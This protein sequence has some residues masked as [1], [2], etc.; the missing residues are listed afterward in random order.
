MRQ[1]VIVGTLLGSLALMLEPA[2]ARAAS[3]KK[4]P[5]TKT[6]KKASGSGSLPS[7]VAARLRQMGC[8]GDDFHLIMCARPRINAVCQNA[9][10]E[11]PGCQ[12]AAVASKAQACLNASGTDAPIGNALAA[13]DAL[14]KEM[15]TA[16][17]CNHGYAETK[18]LSGSC[19]GLASAVASFSCAG[20]ARSVTG[21]AKRLH[22][23]AKNDLQACQ[24]YERRK[25][26]AATNEAAS[27][28]MTAISKASML[29]NAPAGGAPLPGSPG[30]TEC[31][32][33]CQD[34]LM[35]RL[36]RDA[37]CQAN[38]YEGTACRS[39]TSAY[40]DALNRTV[41]LECGC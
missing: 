5:S 1:A 30:A 33:A 14:N 12:S 15:K 4:P 18:V 38:G 22:A 29:C 9:R 27:R 8:S 16:P 41:R 6:N 40:V 34:S 37:I 31:Q 24:N 23:S 10:T 13:M 7:G 11:A 19:S 20:T 36:D 21:N 26:Q 35:K 17:G 39:R 3:A 28:G 25:M 2:T 32:S